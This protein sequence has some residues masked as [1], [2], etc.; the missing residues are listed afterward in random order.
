MDT[1]IRALIGRGGL[2]AMVLCAAVVLS[3]CATGYVLKGRAIEAGYTDVAV[4]PGSD[5]RLDKA[6]GGIEGVRIRVHRDPGHLNQQ[7]VA[8][9]RTSA[10]GSFAIPIDA[11]GAGWMDEQWLIQVER[12]GFRSGAMT[13]RLPTGDRRL[14]VTMSPGTSTPHEDKEDLWEQYERYK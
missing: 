8:T 12:S 4:V 2:T 10:N 5:D 9:G 3:G 11:F 6:G 1:T 7:L 14:L 13:L